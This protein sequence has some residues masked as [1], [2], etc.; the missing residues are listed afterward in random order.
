MR[1]ATAAAG[2]RYKGR[3]DVLL[4]LLAEGTTAAGVLHPLQVPLRAGR[5]VPR[6]RWPGGKARGAGRQFRQRQRLHGQDR[7]GRREAHRGD[8]RQGA[9]LPAPDEIFLASTGVIGEPLDASKFEGVLD[10]CVGAPPPTPLAGA[11]P[12]RS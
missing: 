4:L 1:F 11:P 3:T 10:D 2:I 12:R 6:R 9:G 5:L 8:R 7:R